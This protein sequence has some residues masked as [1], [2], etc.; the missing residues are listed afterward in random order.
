[1]APSVA[2]S[3]W[4]SGSLPF[5][6]GIIPN[7]VFRNELRRLKYCHRITCCVD[8]SCSGAGAAS[9]CVVSLAHREN[10]ARSQAYI[11]SNYLLKRLA[12]YSKTTAIS[13]LTTIA[14]KFRPDVMVIDGKEIA[15]GSIPL[16]P[17]QTCDSA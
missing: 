11:W 17:S 15:I 16:K 5:L 1:V 12:P 9:S 6:I 10:K 13:T 2:V 7:F 3:G 8:H 14:N 4:F